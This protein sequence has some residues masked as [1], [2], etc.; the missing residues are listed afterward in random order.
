MGFFYERVFSIGKRIDFFPGIYIQYLDY[1]ETEK[2]IIHTPLDTTGTYSREVF[3]NYS[4][5]IGLNLNVQYSIGKSLAVTC[6]FTQ[7]DCR[8]WDVRRKIY[9]VNYLFYREL[10]SRINNAY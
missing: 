2:G 9:R 6:R 3:N 7:F 8:I 4:A 5:R 10:N 1:K